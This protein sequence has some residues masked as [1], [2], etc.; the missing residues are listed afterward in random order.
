MTTDTLANALSAVFGTSLTTASD[1]Y[2]KNGSTNGLIS[3]ANLASVLGGRGNLYKVLSSNTD[4]D[5]ITE[6]GIYT[7]NNIS[8]FTNLP[9]DCQGKGASCVLTVMQYTSNNSSQV[10]QLTD[11]KGLYT[12]YKK[13]NGE[14]TPWQV[15]ISS[16]Q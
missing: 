7:Y 13:A 8:N 2:A 9:S 1:V 12:R 14:W 3:A 4:L 10:L 15:H 6:N 11:Y 16:N 5:T